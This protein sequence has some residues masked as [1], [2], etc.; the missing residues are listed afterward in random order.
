MLV[1]DATRQSI[2]RAL[3]NANK[4]FGNNIDFRR[5]TQNEGSTR[6]GGEKWTVTLRAINSAGPGGKLSPSGRRVGGTV[7]WHAYGTFFDYLPETCVI[8]VN[9]P[10]GSKPRKPGDQ[11]IDWYVGFGSRYDDPPRFS[12]L[13][14]C[15]DNDAPEIAAQPPRFGYPRPAPF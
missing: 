8:V 15:S 11:W 4:H 5:C 3:S 9:G 13:C 7:C 14:E 6:Q 12:S 1:R 2:D 10:N